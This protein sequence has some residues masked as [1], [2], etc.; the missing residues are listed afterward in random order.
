VEA[1]VTIQV[2]CAALCSPAKRRGTKKRLFQ[3]PPAKVDRDPPRNFGEGF[4]DVI[5]EMGIDLPFGF[6][7]C[8]ALRLY[9]NI[10]GKRRYRPHSVFHLLG[11]LCGAACPGLTAL[12]RM[13]PSPRR[14][15]DGAA[16]ADFIT[17]WY[18]AA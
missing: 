8:R 10:G 13:K 5:V 9:W 12:S 16:D 11:H 4:C 17:H 6:T 7:R 2:E 1:A 15:M 14:R 3:L 18:H